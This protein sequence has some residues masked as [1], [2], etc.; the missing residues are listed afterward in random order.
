MS[1]SSFRARVVKLL[2]KRMGI[3][4]ENS[5]YPGTPDV[6]YIGGEIELKY[7][8][9]FPIGKDEWIRPSQRAYLR[10]HA[11]CGGKA[12]VLVQ[13]GRGQFYLFPGESAAEMHAP[14]SLE[15]AQNLSAAMFNDLSELPGMLGVV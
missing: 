4:V 10:T 3:P 5:A 1:E 14:I 11:R 6:F 15:D 7:A 2:G 13:V 12:H 9:K 8:V